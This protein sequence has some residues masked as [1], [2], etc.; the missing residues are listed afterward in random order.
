VPLPSAVAI[1]F[2][3]APGE[4]VRAYLAMHW[5]VLRRAILFY[6]PLGAFVLALAFD[7]RRLAAGLYGPAIAES[8]VIAVG[9]SILGLV[10][11]TIVTSW[12]A[13]RLYQGSETFSGLQRFEFRPVAIRIAGP[14]SL[15]LY[16]WS[17]VDAIHESRGYFFLQV[18]DEGRIPVPKR[19][20]QPAG[21]I[22]RLRALIPERLR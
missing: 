7:W 9:S 12:Q 16:P 8:A 15:G 3:Y 17:K 14:D 1:E 2:Q 10:A 20:F 22:E 5:A 13:W 4:F 6:L 11:G 21:E 19:A 18:R